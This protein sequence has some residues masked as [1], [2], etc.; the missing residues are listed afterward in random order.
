MQTSSS[1]WVASSGPSGP[2]PQ[3]A[4]ANFSNAGV[5]RRNPS[6]RHIYIQGGLL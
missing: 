4:G 6:D 2:T 3:F 1:R 5:V